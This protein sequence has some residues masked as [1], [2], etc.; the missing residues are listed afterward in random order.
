M[1]H[2]YEK[3]TKDDGLFKVSALYGKVALDWSHDPHGSIALDWSHNPHGE[4]SAWGNCFQSA[5]QALVRDLS[6][7][8]TYADRE[9]C[10]IVFLYRHSLELSLKALI[11][12]T[13]TLM[14]L[15]GGELLFSKD[16]LGTHKLEPL[17][18]LLE[19]TF[20]RFNKPWVVG[21]ELVCSYDDVAKLVKEFDRFDAGSFAFRYPVNKSF[22]SSALPNHLQFNIFEF[23]RKVD[24]VLEILQRL[25][26]VVDKEVDKSLLDE[27]DEME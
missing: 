25:V 4:M 8:S 11:L 12:E 5:A 24:S 6:K 13:A 23:S 16:M 15:E 19:Q 21:Q 20:A 22:E 7:R 27:P 18:K 3:K 2:E 10:P 1:D 14:R 26:E 17:L 9:A